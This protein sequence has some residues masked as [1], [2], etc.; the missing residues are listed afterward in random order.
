MNRK[1]ELQVKLSVKAPLIS[2]GGGDAVRN[3]NTIFFRSASGELALQHSHIKGK[4][5]EAMLELQQHGCISP[6]IDLQSLFGHGSSK[7]ED[8][9]SLPSSD[10]LPHR[11]RLHFSDFIL[12]DKAWNSR[13]GY[14]KLT[15]VSINSTTGTSKEN[16]LQIIEHLFK[17]GD[18]VVWTGIIS[19]FSKSEEAALIAKNLTLGLKWITAFGGAK[20][21]GFGRLES[22]ITELQP[23]TCSLQQKSAM[24]VAHDGISIHFEFID[25]LLIG[26][27][28]RGTNF[29]ESETVIPGG[30]IKGSLARFLNQLCDT[31]PDTET[32]DLNN[33]SV[34]NHFPLLTK[35][36]SALQFSH[37]FPVDTAIELRPVV[38]PFSAVKTCV[39]E[40]LDA[41]FDVALLQKPLLDRNNKAPVFQ[42]N[43][44]N[45][46]FLQKYFGWS[47]CEIINKTRTAIDPKT[48]R[49]KDESLY[50]F[51]YLTPFKAGSEKEKVKWVANLRFPDIEIAEQEQLLA[52]FIEAIH[53]GWSVLGKR[54]SRFSFTVRD[55][56]AQDAILPLSESVFAKDIAVVV[57]QTDALMFDGNAIAASQQKPDLQRI[58]NNYWQEITDNAC[59]LVRFFARQKFSGGYLSKRF[60]LYDHYY[61]FI[62]TEAGSVFVLKINNREKAEKILQRLQIKGLPLPSTITQR[63]PENREPWELCP[64]VS[65]NGYGEIRINQH[66]H[67]SRLMQVN[68]EGA[69]L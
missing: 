26:G 61:P 63:V 62:L 31:V 58:Y 5:R 42:V 53:Q 17:S 25:D 56:L 21:S 38:I 28:T 69:E 35:Y 16:F 36:F 34:V 29:I 3:L 47:S 48:R 30:V 11:A 37:A 32:I 68:P 51:Q 1:Y 15:K 65:E 54:G 67:W 22:V 12:A 6:A 49:A 60:K 52:E 8:T 2:S 41:Y 10:I 13:P 9:Q 14:P 59:E 45:S 20:S 64:F 39:E 23:V 40:E 19:F 44:K 66:W 50:T 24:S 55:S 57:L 18:I 33:R 4:L 46:G 43:W 7:D 27:I